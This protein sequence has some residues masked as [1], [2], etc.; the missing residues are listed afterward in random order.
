MQYADIVIGDRATSCEQPLTIGGY[1]V[2]FLIEP[3]KEH[4]D[5]KQSSNR[6][7]WCLSFF[8]GSAFE[9][10]ISIFFK[11]AA[12]TLRDP[13]AWWINTEDQPNHHRFEGNI[14]LFLRGSRTKKLDEA[15]YFKQD[16]RL[17]VDR[18]NMVLF[19]NSLERFERAIVCQALALAYKDAISTGMRKLTHCIKSNDEAQLIELYEN[20]LRFNAADYFSHPVDQQKSHELYAIWEQ[21]SKHWRLN[22]LRQDLTDQL[23]GVANLI[24]EQRSRE[25]EQARQKR[26]ETLQNKDSAFNKK[27]I[28]ISVLITTLSLLTLV[29]LTPDTFAR[30][31]ADWFSFFFD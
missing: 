11:D 24:R 2:G 28:L 1:N 5:F 9:R 19:C 31:G 22:E 4:A 13:K 14:S 27:A 18:E 21:L 16:T 10:T 8:T 6:K 3:L 7:A 23:A 17:I 20:M 30:F 25:Q 29:Q 12:D 15:V 26:Q